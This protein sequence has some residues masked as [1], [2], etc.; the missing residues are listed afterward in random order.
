MKFKIPAKGV[1]RKGKSV[2]DC[3]LCKARGHYASDANQEIFY[4]R[5]ELCMIVSE[6]Q[7]QTE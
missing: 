1:A 6:V 4:V 5:D 3:K 7:F 2:V